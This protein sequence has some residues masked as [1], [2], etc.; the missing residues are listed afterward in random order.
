MA[1]LPKECFEA[2]PPFTHVGLDMFGPFETALLRRKFKRYV[3]LFICFSSRAVHMEM[4]MEMTTDS[5]INALRRFICR[6][7]S[8]RSIRCDNGTNFTGAENEFV[9]AFEN[10]DQAKICDHLSLQGCDWILWRWN[11][12][13]ASHM[14]G[15]WERSI[16]SVRATLNAI[17][18]TNGRSLN[19][20]V[21][22]TLICEA[23][24]V[25]NSHPLV[26]EDV[27]DPTTSVLTPSRL[28]TLKTGHILPPPGVFDRVDLYA[29]KRWRAV[30]HLAD[31]FWLRWKR[32][33]VTNLQR[34]QKWSGARRNFAVGDVVLLKQAESKRNQCPL[35]IITKV[36]PS[37]DGLVRSVELRTTANNSTI[38]RPIH[39]LVI[40]EEGSV[41]FRGGV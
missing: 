18:A 6:R 28:L 8:V 17:F 14:G 23:E 2:A 4:T 13:A 7:G 21:L 36:L 24:A 15:A 16:R 35:A 25:I 33:Y 29:R 12:P 38:A 26:I 31:Q 20:G 39:K 1:D 37:D 19:D 22:S 5:L 34:R 32:E 9:R 10:L 40:M 11:T 27:D 3:A 30:Q 41:A